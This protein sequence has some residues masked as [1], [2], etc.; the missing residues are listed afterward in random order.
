MSMRVSVDRCRLTRRFGTSVWTSLGNCPCCMRSSFQAAFTAWVVTGFSQAIPF[1]TRFLT[2]TSLGAC[3]LTAL[4]LA[5]LLAHALKVSVAARQQQDPTGNTVSRRNTM[6]IFARAIAAAAV[7]TSIPALAF[8]ECDQAAAERCQAAAANCRAKCDR[9][10]HREETNRACHQEC[11]SNYVACKG[12][13][14]CS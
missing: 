7:A 14:S 12:G 13:T 11:H 5:H 2:L 6:R 4:W 9:A 3:A 8:A 1:S 10:F